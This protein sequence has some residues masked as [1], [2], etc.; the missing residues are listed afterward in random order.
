MALRWKSSSRRGGGRMAVREWSSA[1]QWQ[2]GGER[3][4]G[5]GVLVA[6]AVCHWI[7]FGKGVP[8]FPLF[9]VCHVQFCQPE[10]LAK[11]SKQKKLGTADLF[12]FKFYWWLRMGL[13]CKNV[14]TTSL[15]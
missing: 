13:R 8:R 12:R 1:W 4:V 2:N 3:V 10:I 14:S 6:H 15:F 9:P 5:G 7:S 11:K